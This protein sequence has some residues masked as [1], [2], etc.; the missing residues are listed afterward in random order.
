MLT[1]SFFVLSYTH[2][3]KHVTFRE[4]YVR[5]RYPQPLIL[6]AMVTPHS[7]PTTPIKDERV[8]ALKGKN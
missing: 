2:D 4:K 3:T 7:P 5:V 8:A 6:T 1:Q